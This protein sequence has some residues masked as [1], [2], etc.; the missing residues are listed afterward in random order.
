MLRREIAQASG[1]RLALPAPKYKRTRI[2]CLFGSIPRFRVVPASGE[3][4]LTPAY[5]PALFHVPIPQLRLP[6]LVTEHRGS[7]SVYTHSTPIYRFLALLALLCASATAQGPHAAKTLSFSS[8]S[9]YLNAAGREP[10]VVEAPDGAPF[11]AP[12]GDPPRPM[13]WKS[14][15]HGATWQRVD[16]GTEGDGAI[17]N[18]DV[19][20]AV[21]HDG[22]LYFANLLFDREKNEGRR[23][24]VGVSTDGARGGAGARSLRNGLPTGLGRRDCGGRCPRYLE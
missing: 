4:V 13:L 1:V 23:V 24:T 21:A 16:V 10:M 11:V 7:R 14:S 18:S 8:H 2:L 22:T 12:Y 6:A 20:L 5:T 15:D 17:G 3:V 19:A 9:D